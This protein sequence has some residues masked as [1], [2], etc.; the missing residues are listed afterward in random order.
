[1]LSYSYLM[2][3]SST[4]DGHYVELLESRFREILRLLLAEVVVDEDWYRDNN[5]DVDEAIRSGALRSAREHYITAGYFENRLPRPIAV[6]EPWYLDEYPDVAAAI[7]QGVFTSA[8][9]HFHRDGFREGRRP[10]AEFSL[11][12]GPTRRLAK[13]A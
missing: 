8:T 5:Q 4:G 6:D 1:M 9:Q 10:S 11:L 12:G 7:R 2:G 13:V 3:P